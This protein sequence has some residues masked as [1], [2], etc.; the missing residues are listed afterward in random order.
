MSDT[1]IATDKNTLLDNESLGNI[2]TPEVR[3]KWGR[4]DS[5]QFEENL[6]LVYEKIVCWKKNLF[7]LPSRRAGKQF[8]EETTKLRNEWLHDSPLKG[9]AFKGSY[10]NAEFIA[11]ETISKIKI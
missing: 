10:D 3:Y 9:I 7:L 8:I 5:Y 4:Y 6:S 2:V 1:V 11:T